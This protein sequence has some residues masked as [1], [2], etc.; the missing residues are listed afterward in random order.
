MAAAKGTPPDARRLYDLVLSSTADC[1]AKPLLSAAGVDDS[2]GSV[3]ARLEDRIRT[4]Q[5]ERDSALASASNLRDNQTAA[6]RVR[7]LVTQ[8]DT[9]RAK[10]GTCDQ[11]LKKL[12]AEARRAADERVGY[13]EAIKQAEASREQS[14]ARLD[15]VNKC[16]AEAG[17]QADV[18][19]ELATEVHRLRQE[20]TELEKSIQSA[21]EA[22]IQSLQKQHQTAEEECRQSV[23]YLR[24][25]AD[26]D[27]PE[28]KET[29]ETLR[30]QIDEN[31]RLRDT[32]K[33][34]KT[35]YADF[36]RQITAQHAAALESNRNEARA[37][38]QTLTQSLD[39]AQQ[40]L[41]VFRSQSREQSEAAARARNEVETLKE[42][43]ENA[44]TKVV[45]IQTKHSAAL[46]DLRDQHAAALEKL[47]EECKTQKETAETR[48]NTLQGQLERESANTEHKNQQQK[49][50][51]AELER[52][53]DEAE[54]RCTEL[55][56]I[57]RKLVHLE[58]ANRKLSEELNSRVTASE[59]QFAEESAQRLKSLQEK[60]NE[61]I[62]Y[63]ETQLTACEDEKQQ[64]AN[65]IAQLKERHAQ[66]LKE[67]QA[68]KESATTTAEKLRKRIADLED[69]KRT[70]T[71]TVASMENQIS[72][73]Q[74]KFA[75]AE[76]NLETVAGRLDTAT[77]EHEKAE[78]NYQKTHALLQN[79]MNERNTCNDGLKAAQAEL[80]DCHFQQLFTTGS[81]GETLEELYATLYH[82]WVDQGVLSNGYDEK[83]IADSEI[84][85]VVRNQQDRL[86]GINSL[87]VAG[88]KLTNKDLK[89][90]CSERPGAIPPR[91]F[92]VLARLAFRT[93]AASESQGNLQLFPAAVSVVPGEDNH[94]IT[95][96]QYVLR[97][98]MK[99][100]QTLAVVMYDRYFPGASE[101]EQYR[102]S[103][104]FFNAPISDTSKWDVV[105]VLCRPFDDDRNDP[106]GN[107][108][109]EVIPD[110]YEGQNIG[111]NVFD[112]LPAAD[113]V[114]VAKKYGAR[115]GNFY[116]PTDEEFVRRRLWSYY[117]QLLLGFDDNRVRAGIQDLLRAP[118][119]LRYLFQTHFESQGRFQTFVRW[120]KKDTKASLRDVGVATA[121]APSGETA[122]AVKDVNDTRKFVSA[123]VT[124]IWSPTTTQSEV[125]SYLWP[126]G[127]AALA[128]GR[129]FVAVAYGATGSGKSYTL[130]GR[131]YQ[132]DTS[133][134][135]LLPR[136]LEVA[137]TERPG[138]IIRIA[139]S[140]LYYQP[141]N[142]INRPFITRDIFE[143]NPGLKVLL[144]KLNTSSGI[145]IRDTAFALM[146]GVMDTRRTRDRSHS[147]SSRSVLKIEVRVGNA[148]PWF[149]Y[150][151]PGAESG[152]TGTDNQ[153]SRKFINPVRLNV[154]DFLIRKLIGIDQDPTAGAITEVANFLEPSMFSADLSK[155][156]TAFIVTIGAEK[157]RNLGVSLRHQ[158]SGDLSRLNAYA[159]NVA[160]EAGLA[161]RMFRH[162]VRAAAKRALLKTETTTTAPS[163]RSSQHSMAGAATSMRDGDGLNSTIGK[164]RGARHR[165]GATI[166]RY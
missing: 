58:N 79:A 106:I 139:V 150:D 119:D 26:A 77:S 24:T 62:G 19:A 22:K 52:N 6:P 88:E 64:A 53:L 82:K 158:K 105:A 97:N 100:G 11:E 122:L 70:L 125:F 149:F 63:L 50:R 41:E 96:L 126:F 45:C 32:L 40:A 155:A 12:Q 111:R 152:G 16:I 123:N 71:A 159:V 112:D 72:E 162:N 4:L 86:R 46:T 151:F 78:Q 99:Y 35:E 127:R 5:K 103:T 7:D 164:P 83:V 31:K 85:N 60:H 30:R 94:A 107:V 114:A 23:E 74:T 161:Y 87:Q 76:A 133:D 8:L 43:L 131:R 1:W 128:H 15:E 3:L 145:Y 136:L 14:T 130:L 38:V 118:R 65:D 67:I 98:Q 42:Q 13:E 89:R 56:S 121:R 55:A 154:K 34:V 51:I 110:Y 115:V 36:Q 116:Q 10:C 102:Y 91:V 143:T 47:Q 144:E 61:Q 73:L 101:N 104:V 165:H 90:F 37:Q 75:N 138:Q 69:K 57:Q 48:A 27:R 54:D 147:E 160:V 92:I 166:R 113:A 68:K 84:D 157:G 20:K 29:A 80:Q 17:K 137:R 18:N 163:T 141:G 146:E 108:I 33:A 2:T 21:H 81:G 95:Y 135:G 93:V 142:P 120:H 28:A 124:Q 129:P 9:C 66:V 156:Y 132:Q 148:A 134:F 153:E 49:R 25:Q 44:E 117:A 140:E 39:K 109:E 59:T